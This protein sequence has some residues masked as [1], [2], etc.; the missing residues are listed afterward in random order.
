M[1]V[2]NS[3]KSD[4]ILN[5]MPDRHLLYTAKEMDLNGILVTS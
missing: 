5:D 2:C 3:D 4:L 1:F